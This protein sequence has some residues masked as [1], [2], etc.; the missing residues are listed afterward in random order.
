MV[1]QMI[2]KAKLSNRT[3][4]KGLRSRVFRIRRLKIIFLK[5]TLLKR[6]GRSNLRFLKKKSFKFVIII[7]AFSH[8]FSK[9]RKLLMSFLT[10]ISMKTSRKCGKIT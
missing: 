6:E 1:L 5:I 2:S 8:K 9:M 10:K 4:C 3:A 7:Q